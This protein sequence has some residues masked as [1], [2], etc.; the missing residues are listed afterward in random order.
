MVSSEPILVALIGN[1]ISA[2]LSPALHEAEG[3]EAGLR[4]YYH[5]VDLSSK[6][7]DRALPQALDSTQFLGFTGCNI[8]HPFKV[9]SIA[10][11]DEL[12]E[13]ASILGAVNTVSYQKGRRIGYNTDWLGF[14]AGF[15]GGLPGV[16]FDS[17]GIVGAG[18]AGLAVGYALL[19]LGAQ[20]IKVFDSQAS[21]ARAFV[22]RLARAFPGSQIEIAEVVAGTMEADGV[23]NATPL[24]MVGHP[25]QAVPTS[26]LRPDMWVADV[27]YTPLETELLKHAAEAGCRVLPGGPMAVHQAAK[28]FEIFSGRSADA[29]RMLR[30]FARLQGLD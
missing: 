8:T 4:Y 14:T 29:Q 17:V 19:R 2:S 20:V 11:L 12:T 1:G 6:D 27:V 24:G 23:V 5:L 3:R 15:L 25:G 28:A 13:D 9:K 10:Y 22:E 7:A 18:G 16:P 21:Q 30:H 26:L